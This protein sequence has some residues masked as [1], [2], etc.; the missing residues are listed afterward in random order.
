MT[1][2]VDDFVVNGRRLQ[3]PVMGTCELRGDKIAAW[4]DYYDSAALRAFLTGAA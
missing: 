1:E 4:R 2:R 3:L